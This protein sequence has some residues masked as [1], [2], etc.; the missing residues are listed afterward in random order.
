[1]RSIFLRALFVGVIGLVVFLSFRAVR[2]THSRGAA[3]YE[4]WKQKADIECAAYRAEPQHADELVCVNDAFAPLTFRV[5]EAAEASLLD[6]RAALARGDAVSASRALGE[7]TR[8]ARILKRSGTMGAVFS[9][10][11]VDRLLPMVGSDAIESSVRRAALEAL[12]M[13]VAYAPFLSWRI[14]RQ[15][16]LAHLLDGTA[17]GDPSTTADQLADV[18]DQQHA[19]FHAMERAMRD[20]DVSKCTDAADKIDEE[21]RGPSVGLCERMAKVRRAERARAEALAQLR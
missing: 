4:G 13:D 6:A 18:M 11:L 3:R 5:F 20:D 19:Q 10:D 7:M 9:A 12:T 21:F 17:G 16:Q 1:M 15:W 14:D 2:S 8:Q